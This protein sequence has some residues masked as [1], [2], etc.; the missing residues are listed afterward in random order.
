MMLHVEAGH[1]ADG[2]PH[3][4]GSIE[5]EVLLTSAGMLSR[6]TTQEQS[7]PKMD[8]ESAMKRE[9]TVQNHTLNETSAS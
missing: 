2:V 8:Q 1:A 4:D 7:M 3:V 5:V 6:C 9:R